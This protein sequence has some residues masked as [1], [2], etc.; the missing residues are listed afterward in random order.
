M[1]ITVVAC[2]T[3]GDVQPAAVIAAEL[4]RR[5]HD[6]VLAT[7]DDLVPFGRAIGVTTV[8]LGFEIRAF[9]RSEQ[10]AAFMATGASRAYLTGVVAYKRSKTET[11]FPAF[12]AACA[13]ADVIVS[14][15]LTLDEARCVGAAEH[16]PVIGL[17]H[18]PR[19]Q[20]P[21]FPSFIVTARRV[22]RLLRPLTHLL[23]SA[24]DKRAKKDYLAEFRRAMGLSASR[25]HTSPRPVLE[26]Q[27]YSALIVPELRTWSPLRPLTGFPE[28]TPEQHA[29]W[30][31]AV[32]DESLQHWLDAGDPP[33]YFGF[34]SMPVRD[35]GAVTAMIRR[36]CE[37][38]GLRG[39]IGAGWS[40]LEATEQ[41]DRIR[42]VG[43]VDHAALLP[44]CAVA[45][46]HGGAGTT[47]AAVAAGVPSVVCAVA[48]D[49]SFWGQRL[50]DR[51]IGTW[52]PFSEMSETTLV[53]AI[54]QLLEPSVRRRA[55]ELRSQLVVEDGTRG[56]ADAICDAADRHLTTHR[57]EACRRGSR[58]SGP[59]RTV[60]AE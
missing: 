39:L 60:G 18:A 25:Q 7:A 30:G 12:A 43:A 31:D 4:G 20:N 22:P 21:A 26:V 41:H 57:T 58:T 42:V 56:A 33:V 50:E 24:W 19:R 23:A 59:G 49:Q 55:S 10:G 36:V 28:A 37:T 48:F 52:L 51:G 34:G 32:P 53:R 2:G 17:F 14:N 46:H 9:L 27:A 29:L 5:G 16:I 40:D 13:G 11:F 38:L 3:R 1:R 45:V 47:A 6:V 44:R 54:R 35:P 8:P 15:H